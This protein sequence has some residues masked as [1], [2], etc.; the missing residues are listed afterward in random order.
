[1]NA[2]KPADR[3]VPQRVGFTLVE[4][5]VVISIVAVLIA[6]LLP[7]LGQ[8]R[9]SARTL[10]C[11]NQLR[12]LGVGMHT[13]SVDN[14]NSIPK[15]I[16]GPSSSVWTSAGTYSWDLQ[17]RDY[18]ASPRFDNR[19]APFF[20]RVR[21]RVNE[22]KFYCPSYEK[23]PDGVTINGMRF[24][25]S[26][27]GESYPSLYGN[28]AIASYEVN[29]WSTSLY[30]IEW[31]SSVH[32]FQLA[33]PLARLDDMVS[34]TM[35]MTELKDVY[36]DPPR[37]NHRYI[38]YNPN[39]S[40]AVPMLFADNRVERRKFED[41]PAAPS[42]TET[43]MSSLSKERRDFWGVDQL[44]FYADPTAVNWKQEP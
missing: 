31:T 16:L 26:V 1:M 9:Q 29:M 37:M 19:Y 17:L 11:Q 20:T 42:R 24:A 10:V 7:A 2:W 12:Q 23:I 40:G 39:H 44:R 34:D 3:Y 38:Y 6:L 5:L 32:R 36:R 33:Q 41:V 35:I 4:L 27:T 25:S 30:A 13:Y 28:Q 8:A 15:S 14:E 43:N 21:S 18:L 22:L